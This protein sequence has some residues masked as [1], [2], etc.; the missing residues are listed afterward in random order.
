MKN[1]NKKKLSKMIF[2]SVLLMIAFCCRWVNYYPYFIDEESALYVLYPT[3]KNVIRNVIHISLVLMWCLSIHSRIL[4]RRIRNH[5]MAV[6]YLIMTWFVVRVCKWDFVMSYEATLVRYLWYCFYIPIILIPLQGLF[7]ADLVGQPQ[8]YRSPKWMKWLYIPAGVLILLVFTNDLHQ[9]V[10]AFPKGIRAFD[11]NYTHEL[12]YYIIILWLIVLV[13]CFIVILMKKSRVPGAENYQNIPFI[14]I[15]GFA[16][17]WVVH[18]MKWIQM[19]QTFLNCM[20]IILLLESQ[21]QTGLIRSNSN[22]DTLFKQSTIAAR[23]VDEDYQLCYASATKMQVDKE[24][25]RQTDG[26]AVVA[27]DL[28][29]HSK[30]IAGGKVLWADNIKEINGIVEE[31]QETQAQ[32]GESYELKKAE[33]DLKERKF[34]AEEKSRLYDRIAHEV[35]PQLAKADSILKEARKHPEKQKELLAQICVISAYIKRLSN[36]LLISEEQKE[37]SANELESCLRES[38]DNL[39]LAN[40]LSFLDSRCE[41]Q[42]CTKHI[43]E[44]YRIFESI[45]EALLGKM[46]AMVVSMICKDGNIRMRM[47]VGLN[48]RAEEQQ[49]MQYEIPGG[50]VSWEVQEEDIIIELF[51]EEGGGRK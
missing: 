5:L 7:I 35:S 39:R 14:I 8:G 15:G 21:I 37:V 12:P 9:K 48:S 44:V 4:D 30:P 25:L 16:A 26:G 24:L 23:I 3:M 18:T 27:G 2:I 13:I 51:R 47:Q 17:V 11:Q 40:V 20:L 41:G 6:G 33:V 22:Y 32:L 29:L 1:L 19:D 50:S 43:T 36:L 28:F 34:Q 46:N 38:M 31:L 49:V 45:T 10:F 42:V